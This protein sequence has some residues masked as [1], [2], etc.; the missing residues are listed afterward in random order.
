MHF[1]WHDIANHPAS[2]ENS[3]MLSS[4]YVKLN[5]IGAA[6]SYID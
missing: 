1:A 4:S 3:A 6:I 5:W 2:L